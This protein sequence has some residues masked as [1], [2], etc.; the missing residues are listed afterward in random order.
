M[1]A[2]SEKNLIGVNPSL[3]EVIKLA[4]SRH[5]FVVT[6]GLRT[7]ERQKQLVAE[8]KSQTMNSNHLTGNAVDIYCGSWEP[9]DFLPALVEIYKAAQ[10]L[11]VKLRFGCNWSS[12]PEDKTATKFKDWPHVEM[13]K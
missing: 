1:D 8:G 12:N 10:E 4:K 11:G 6:E 5:D 7:I 2:R 9:K 13:G 3:V